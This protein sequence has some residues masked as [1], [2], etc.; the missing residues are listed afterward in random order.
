MLQSSIVM[1][2]FPGVVNLP[3]W[4]LLV[5][6]LFGSNGKK[7]TRTQKFLRSRWKCWKASLMWPSKCP[8]EAKTNE[9]M[10]GSWRFWSKLSG[11]IITTSAEVTLNGGLVRES[12]QYPLN[13]GLGIILICPELWNTTLKTKMKNGKSTFLKMYFLLNIGSFYCQVGFRECFFFRACFK[14]LVARFI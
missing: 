13:S 14:T 9:K 11:Q 8:T 12:L 6:S 2:V 1:L 7:K 5:I 4:A 10:V 3:G